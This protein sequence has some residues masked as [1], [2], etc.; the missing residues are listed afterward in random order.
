MEGR[1][2]LTIAVSLKVNDGVVLATDS[3]MTV[4]DRDSALIKY[5]YDNTTKIFSFNDNIPIGLLVYGLGTINHYPMPVVIED[6]KRACSESG[7]WYVDSEKYTVASVANTIMKYL[8]KRYS[9][10][11]S[12][13]SIER[14]KLGCFIVGYSPDSNISQEFEIDIQGDRCNI[15]PQPNKCGLFRA[16]SAAAVSC[17]D[18]LLYGCDTALHNFFIKR[19]GSSPSDLISV[20]EIVSD[21]RENL[22]APLIAPPMPIH[23]AIQLATFF[24]KTA[25]EYQRFMPGPRYVGGPVDVAI[26]TRRDSFKWIERKRYVLKEILESDGSQ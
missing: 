7:E 26:I 9:E 22:T 17:V 2:T 5:V 12:A 25:I 8:Y 19:Y 23:D 11:F 10:N 18:R 4:A 16:G 21:I 3:A 14:P 13:G 24:V 20:A 15:I 6:L 1:C